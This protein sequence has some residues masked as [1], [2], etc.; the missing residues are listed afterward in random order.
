MFVVNSDKGHKSI[1]YLKSWPK[2]KNSARLLNFYIWF[3][4][5]NANVCLEIQLRYFEG[6]FFMTVALQKPEV[7]TIKNNFFL[8]S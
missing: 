7:A 8:K 5:T 4:R 3:S 6:S 2:L 1:I